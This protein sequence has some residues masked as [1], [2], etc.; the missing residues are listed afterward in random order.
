[1]NLSTLETIVGPINRGQF[2]TGFND[3][4]TTPK[5]LEPEYI[6]PRAS[7]VPKPVYELEDLSHLNPKC[8]KARQ[9]AIEKGLL[10]MTPE[11]HAR[12]IDRLKKAAKLGGL[13]LKPRK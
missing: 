12:R 5:H 4:Y 6:N 1:M 7:T 2:E 10:S 3:T 9:R 11:D 8:S 13:A